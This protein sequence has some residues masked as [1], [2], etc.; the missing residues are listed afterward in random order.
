MNEVEVYNAI[1]SEIVTN[2]VLLNL[3]TLIVV[4]VLLVGICFTEN[5]KSIIS[6]M[7]PLLTLSW[8]AATVRFDYFIHRQAAYLRVAEARMQESGIIMPLWETWKFSLRSTSIIVP[9][10]DLMAILVILIPTAYLLFG[11]TQEFFVFKLWRGRKAYAWGVSIAIGFLLCSLLFI[12][13][14]ASR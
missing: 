12:P 4:I 8:A 5:R 10:A 14:M 6:V 13:R 3:T 7:L 2:H 11:P 1:R 9:I